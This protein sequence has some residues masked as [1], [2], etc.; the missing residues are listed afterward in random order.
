MLAAVGPRVAP[1]PRNPDV[2][3]VSS[4]PRTTIA[5]DPVSHGCDG[6]V[7]RVPRRSHA[8]RST[9]LQNHQLAKSCVRRNLAHGEAVAQA[10]PSIDFACTPALVDALLD[11]AAVRD[12]LRWRARNSEE[13]EEDEEF[14]PVD[15][16]DEIKQR[17]RNR[18][19]AVFATK[20]SN[21]Q[22]GGASCPS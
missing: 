9:V 4:L 14:C 20:S 6:Q 10:S 7:G 18:A 5:P 16:L 3:N 15:I 2:V 12:V 8:P 1:T 11:K 22:R 13:H 21:P 17:S 19:V